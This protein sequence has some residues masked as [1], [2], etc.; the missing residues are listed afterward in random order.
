MFEFLLISFSVGGGAPKTPAVETQQKSEEPRRIVETAGDAK[1]TERK[2]VPPGRSG[3]VFAGIGMTIFGIVCSWMTLLWT[4][5]Y[6]WDEKDLGEVTV[7]KE[8]N[9]EPPL[10]G[11]DGEEI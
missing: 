7:W 10:K 2:R 4:V 1:K 9:G 3:N 6:I 11:T 8:S 5:M